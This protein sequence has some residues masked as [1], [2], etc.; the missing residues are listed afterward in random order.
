MKG[1]V[2]L[3]PGFTMVAESFNPPTVETGLV[4]YL[5][6]KGF[7]VWLL[8]YRA[9][10]AVPAVWT[11]FTLD[12]I[13]RRDYPAAVRVVYERTGGKKVQIVA[14]CVG[15][16]SLFMSLLDG[17]LE[18]W[19]RSVVCS[20]STAY[21]EMARFTEAKSGA[22]L[23]ALLKYLG[24]RHISASFDPRAWD[25]WLVDQILKL[26]PTH[27][28]CNNPVCRR[29]LFIFHEIYRHEQLNAE[30]HDALWLWF[31]TSSI[32]ALRH[33]TLMVR[34]GYVVDAEG[35]D[36]YLCHDDPDRHQRQLRRL[37]LPISFMH[38]ELNHAF[39]PGSTLNTY[40]R[41]RAV[42]GRRWYRWKR[43]KGYAHFDCFAGRS[44]AGYVFPWIVKQLE[45]PPR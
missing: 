14:H 12:D 5:S 45:N 17:Q 11:S 38:G 25:D 26:Y 20:Q 43:F 16:V 35:Q 9:S 33:L 37:R 32:A 40:R 42:N 15:S 34:T 13:A 3:V 29:I 21:F 18:G 36:V 22:Y 24:V 27:E 30:T 39:L 1:P 10:P 44:A 28:R 2:L 8:D 23:A 31:G 6:A 41:L 7:D 4:Q 19:V